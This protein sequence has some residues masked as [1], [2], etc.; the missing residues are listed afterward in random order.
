MTSSDALSLGAASGRRPSG[1]RPAVEPVGEASAAVAAET[2][3]LVRRACL[4]AHPVQGRPGQGHPAW[5]G[6]LLGG[7]AAR[8][9]PSRT[10]DTR[11]SE[12]HT[13]IGRAVLWCLTIL[14]IIMAHQAISGVIHGYVGQPMHGFASADTYPLD[15]SPEHLP[16]IEKRLLPLFEP[17]RRPAGTQTPAERS[18][19]PGDAG[20]SAQP[21][22]RGRLQRMINK[23][24]GDHRVD[25]ALLAAVV[26]VESGH[27]VM[28]VSVKG[29]SGLMQ[30]MPDTA[31]RYGVSDLFDP[32][33]NLD[34]GA[35][36]LAFLLRLF[37]CDL[38][39]ALAAYNAGEGA[40]KRHGNVIP[41]YPETQA[42]VPKVLQRYARLHD[43]LAVAGHG[44]AHP[45]RPRLCPQAATQLAANLE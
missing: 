24:A 1:V 19:E 16:D 40:V 25:P 30:L 41:P 7:P 33:Q 8:Q 9:N 2:A 4:P 36:H 23:A 39:L 28:A 35:R 15:Y 5:V 21:L 37:D 34:A 44:A 12:S 29:A 13:L 18:G 43:G 26:S 45:G 6:R 11:R 38:S 17:D 22:P 31:S 20:G 3:W 42:Y 14:L 32:A 10:S 27:D